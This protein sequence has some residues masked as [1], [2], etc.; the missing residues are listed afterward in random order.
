MTFY[1]F[2]SSLLTVIGYIVLVYR[3][4][5]ELESEKLKKVRQ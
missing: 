5:F 3:I 2:T 1:D 4:V